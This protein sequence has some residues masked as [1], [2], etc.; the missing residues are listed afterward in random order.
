MSDRAV[1][2]A[3]IVDDPV[4]MVISTSTFAGVDVGLVLAVRQC[5]RGIQPFRVWTLI[6]SAVRLVTRCRTL[7]NPLGLQKANPPQT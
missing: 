2:G 7:E 4:F 1:P 3:A 6:E 5:C